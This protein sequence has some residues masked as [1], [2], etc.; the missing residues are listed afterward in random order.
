MIMFA[1][2]VVGLAIVAMLILGVAI[3]RDFY[4]SE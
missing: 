2:I 3:L 4:R 1:K